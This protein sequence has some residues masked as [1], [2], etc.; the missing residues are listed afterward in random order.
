MGKCVESVFKTNSLKLNTASHTTIW[1]TDTGGF[2]EHSPRGKSLYF[3]EPALQK[4]ILVVW[5]APLYSIIFNP[6]K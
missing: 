3:K 6:D 5:G 1:Y 2:L 4:I